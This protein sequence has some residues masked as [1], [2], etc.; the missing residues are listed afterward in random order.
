MTEA[1]WQVEQH[2][3]IVC[4]KQSHGR[5][6]V[7]VHGDITGPDI[8]ELEPVRCVPGG[9]QQLVKFKCEHCQFPWGAW[10]SVPHLCPPGTLAT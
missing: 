7:D 10:V 8:V 2:Q 1:P 3:C 9:L 4:R 6:M 5:Y